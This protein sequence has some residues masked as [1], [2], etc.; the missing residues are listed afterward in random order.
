L[1]ELPSVVDAPLPE[2][3]ACG[4]GPDVSAAPTPE[5]APTAAPSWTAGADPIMASDEPLD[6]D[7]AAVC[8]AD[9]NAAPNEDGSAPG[10]SWAEG[11][12]WPRRA[13]FAPADFVPPERA[14]ETRTETPRA[15]PRR[16]GLS[17]AAAPAPERSAARLPSS[18]RR[19]PATPER[20]VR[21]TGAAVDGRDGS[22]ARAR[23]GLSVQRSSPVAVAA[24]AWATASAR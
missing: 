5:I 8:E 15:L 20:F 12:A 22:C 10:F 13:D 2:T 17:A 24:L 14:C 16:L 6:V 9:V 1:D 19:P 4:A 18:S 21:Q 7:P 3:L 11:A 23:S